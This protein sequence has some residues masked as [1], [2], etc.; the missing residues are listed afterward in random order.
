[1]KLDVV[2]LVRR[3]KRHIK[4]VNGKDHALL[5]RHCGVRIVVIEFGPGEAGE[6]RKFFFQAPE[7]VVEGAVFQ[8]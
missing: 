5:V 2:E 6:G 7:E 3:I 8:H 4:P 1:L